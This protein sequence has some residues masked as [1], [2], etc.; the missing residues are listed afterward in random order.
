MAP[1]QATRIGW[2]TAIAL[3]AG[4]VVILIMAE[5]FSYRAAARLGGF[6][7]IG[8]VVQDPQLTNELGEIVHCHIFFQGTTVV[9]G[10]GG[11]QIQAHLLATGK[12]GSAPGYVTMEW[13]G[14]EWRVTQAAFAWNG[15]WSALSD[16]QAWLTEIRS[17]A[18]RARAAPC[19]FSLAVLSTAIVWFIVLLFGSVA[20]GVLWFFGG[21]RYRISGSEFMIMR[22][23]FFPVQQFSL[24]DVSAL[25]RLKVRDIASGHTVAGL[26]ALSKGYGNWPKWPGWKI[27]LHDGRYFLV[28][29][30]K[31]ILLQLEECLRRRA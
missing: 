14:K 30:S 16:P 15:R 6:E 28:T 7:N 25:T 4:M 13:N 20:V 29:P 18:V 24:Q 1:R 3:L 23:G 10:N 2:L 21:Y 19:T 5:A 31:R 12:K 17:G 27:T 9:F 8:L 22:F 11:G 26:L